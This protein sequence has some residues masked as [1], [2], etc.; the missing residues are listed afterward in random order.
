MSDYI[1][2]EFRLVCNAVLLGIILTFI[3]DWLR[4]MR[5]VLHHA[6]WVVSFEDFLYWCTCFVVSFSMLY[7]E[8]NGVMRW[9]HI[10]GAM[11]GMILYKALLGQFLVKYMTKFLQFLICRMKKVLVIIGRPIYEKWKEIRRRAILQKRTLEKKRYLYRKKLTQQ[12]KVI[13][14][15]LKN[16]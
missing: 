1:M 9:F 15:V 8:N 14:M 4:I 5:R 6:Q 11:I 10:I 16:K 3:Y 7:R 2:K 13:K 12:I